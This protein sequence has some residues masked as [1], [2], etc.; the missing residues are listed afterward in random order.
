M[1]EQEEN[2]KKITKCMMDLVKLYAKDKKPIDAD[3]DMFGVHYKLSF[4][5][6]SSKQ[7]EEKI[8][9][10]DYTNGAEKSEYLKGIE[11]F[12]NYQSKE[13]LADTEHKAIFIMAVD[14]DKLLCCPLGTN[15]KLIVALASA[16]KV[17][18][19]AANMITFA[20]MLFSGQGKS[21]EDLI[22]AIFKK[23]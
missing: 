10:T 6:E 11:E 20:S 8:K 22:K 13:T 23:E 17:N 18:E 14:G 15:R 12:A 2:E 19:N 1:A 21:T 3:L 9:C 16:M 7:K 5:A 4:T